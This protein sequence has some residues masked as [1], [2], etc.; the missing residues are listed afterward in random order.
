VHEYLGMVLDYT[1]DGIL[2]IDMWDYVKK[3]LEDIPERMDGTATTPA[4]LYIFE[5]RDG[6]ENLSTQSERNFSIL[7]WLSCCFCVNAGDVIS[8]Q[9]SHS[10]A[11]K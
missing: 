1:E 10:C 11:L 9:Q 4:T 5:V 2:K 8:K 7:L 3:L 6:I